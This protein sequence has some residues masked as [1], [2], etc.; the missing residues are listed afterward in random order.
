[1][2]RRAQ[3]GSSFFESA[4][5]SSGK[6]SGGGLSSFFPT[7]SYQQ[8]LPSSVQQLLNHRRGVPDVSADADPD[9]AMLVY[10]NGWDFIGGTSAVAPLWAAI[11]AI[12]NQMAGRPLGFLNP[13]LYRLAASASYARDF[14]DVTAGNNNA[15]VNGVLVPGYNAVQGWDPVTGLGTPD[16]ENLI[17]DLIAAIN[18]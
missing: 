2:L 7:P 17:P 14:H 18:G 9:T 1:M 8:A 13:A 5:N 12:A 4:W 3:V 11:A 6:S 10:F 16:A 15:N